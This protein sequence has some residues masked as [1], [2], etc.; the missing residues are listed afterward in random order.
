M[1]PLNNNHQINKQTLVMDLPLVLLVKMHM[2]V[3]K[4]MELLVVLQVMVLLVVNLI[5]GKHKVLLISMLLHPKITV[6][7]PKISDHHLNNL[8]VAIMGHHKAIMAH[9]LAIMD[10]IEICN[11]HHNFHIHVQLQTSKSRLVHLD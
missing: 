1:V 5:S 6:L 11:D 10:N 4:V 7:L 9:L 8:M 3:L 2:V